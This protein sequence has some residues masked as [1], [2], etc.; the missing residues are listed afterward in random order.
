MNEGRPPLEDLRQESL[1]IE[2]SAYDLLTHL[3][4]AELKDAK[5]VA[6]WLV[7]RMGP[8]GRFA[9]SD[10]RRTLI[11]S[12]RY[13]DGTDANLKN[14]FLNCLQSTKFQCPDKHV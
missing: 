3:S 11:N 14:V 2:T 1:E 8:D 13:S 10:V 9:S 12:S 6:N 7:Q 4:L 5:S